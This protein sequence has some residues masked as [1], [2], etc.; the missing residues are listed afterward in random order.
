MDMDL[1]K[2]EDMSQALV[3]TDELSGTKKCREFLN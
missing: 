1:T 3:N 2:D